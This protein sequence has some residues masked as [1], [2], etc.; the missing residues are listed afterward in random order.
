MAS[1]ELLNCNQQQ[2]SSLSLQTLPL[3]TVWFVYII[4]NNSDSH[5]Y[6][7]KSFIYLTDKNNQFTTLK[8]VEYSHIMSNIIITL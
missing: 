4:S 5:C 7:L 2:S 8:L 3:I 1:E 6:S